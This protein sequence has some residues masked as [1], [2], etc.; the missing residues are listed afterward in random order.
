MKMKRKLIVLAATILA[1]SGAYANYPDKPIKIIV[2][3]AAGGPTDVVAR[4]LADTLGRTLGGTIIVENKP[5]AG[6]S[7]GSA[8]VARS[9]A[10]GYTL[11]VAA[12]STH[13]VNPACNS[14]NTYHPVNDFTPISLVADMPMIMAIQPKMKEKNFAEVLRYAKSTSVSLTQGTSGQCTLQHMLVEKFNDQMKIKIKGIP[15]RGSAPALN[16][17]MGGNLDILMDVGYLVQPLVKSG[18]AKPI[19]VISSTRLDSMP[20]VPTIEELGYKDLNMRPW[21]GL[22]A[23]K[24]IPAEVEKKLIAAVDKAMRDERLI[25]TF[26]NAGMNPL[27]GTNGKDF[28][29]KILKEFEENKS[30]AARTNVE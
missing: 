12:V 26:K 9:A 28:S 23:P 6:G 27:T 21:Y 2:P 17:F 24:G 3:F 13:V 4:S 16:D 18:R 10:D 7:L 29:K 5:G 8:Q 11:G 19:A 30:F 14:N 25:E 15:Y 1:S 20:E 22:V